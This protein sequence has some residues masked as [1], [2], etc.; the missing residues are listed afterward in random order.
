MS[1]ARKSHKPLDYETFVRLTSSVRDS[2][3]AAL[4]IEL[5]FRLLA[6]EEKP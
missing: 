4:L 2:A 1:E 3:A 5:Y 6:L